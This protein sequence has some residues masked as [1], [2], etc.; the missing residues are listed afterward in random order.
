MRIKR[1]VLLVVLLLFCMMPI[2]PVTAAYGDVSPQ[3]IT[4]F[5]EEV[6]WFHDGSNTTGI[7]PSSGDGISSDGDILTMTSDLDGAWFNIT[8]SITTANYPFFVLNCTSISLGDGW[9]LEQYDGAVWATLQS[10]YATDTGIYRYNMLALDSSVSLF[11]VNLTQTATIKFDFF[12]AYGIENFTITQDVTVTVT[13]V[14]YVNSNNALVIDKTTANYIQFSYDISL[15]VVVATYNI[16][17]LSILSPSAADYI[18]FYV[19]GSWET[20]YWSNTN[21]TWTG[22]GILT[23]LQFVVYYD[24]TL[25]TIKFITTYDWQEIDTVTVW[26]VVPFDQWPIT[27]FYILLGFG[28]VIFSGVFLVYGGRKSMS[29]DKLLYFLLLFMIGWGLIIGSVMS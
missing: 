16:W 23:D 13:E 1:I 9:K 3:S 12:T 19:G 17:N 4:S 2:R 20:H 26:F 27:N 10:S 14:A 8:T 25:S 7:A 29:T 24:E 22:T 11:R 15:S 6:G 18:Q 5:A 28:M 21:G